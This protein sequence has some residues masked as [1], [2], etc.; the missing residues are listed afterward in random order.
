[1]F[2]SSKKKLIVSGCSYSDN[3][4]QKQKI[5]DFDVYGYLLAKKLNMNLVNTSVCGSGNKSIYNRVINHILN[6]DKD[7]IGLVICMWSELQRVCTYSWDTSDKGKTGG[8]NPWQ[9]FHP[10]RTVLDAEWHEE[11]F[12][13]NSKYITMQYKLSKLLREYHLDSIKLGVQDFHSYAFAFQNICE[14][15]EIPYLQIFGPPLLLGKQNPHH[16]I[17]YEILQKCIIESQYYDR[18]KE[19]FIGWPVVPL[20]FF[21]KK[22][23]KTNIKYFSFDD[24]L[25]PPAGWKYYPHHQAVEKGLKK[26]REWIDNEYRIS[27][28]DSHPNGKGHE[29]ITEVLENAYQKIYS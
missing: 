20:Q 7:D 9:S 5:G 21:P 15:L 13:N 10:E 19:T 24:L 4:A 16:R 11:K 27:A 3:Y 6:N 22:I 28:E 17:Q 23:K 25:G 2:K 12:N 1:M 26:D 18:M 14:N 8:R 29:L